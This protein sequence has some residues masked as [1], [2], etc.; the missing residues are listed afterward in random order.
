M[1][2]CRNNIDFPESM[3]YIK[4]SLLP[5]AKNIQVSYFVRLVMNE[6]K[7]MSGGM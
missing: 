1:F 6:M 4:T 3:S 2:A 5:I 7:T